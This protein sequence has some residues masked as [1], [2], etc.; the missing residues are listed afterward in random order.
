MR[1]LLLLV[2]AI[3]AFLLAA[4]PAASA[5]EA[6]IRDAEFKLSAGGFQ[7]GLKA[8]AEG[9]KATLSL[10]RHGQVAIYQVPAE[11]TENTVKAKFGKFGE[12]DY[13]FTPA[14]GKNPECKGAD[15][16][17]EG[18]FTGNFDFTGENHY[19]SFEADH[20]HGTFEIFPTE[21][22]EEPSK[23]FKP[24]IGTPGATKPGSNG[25]KDAKPDAGNSEDQ[26]TLGVASRGKRFVSYLLVSPLVTK[27][28]GTRIFFY[29]FRAEKLKGMLVERG[30][31]VAAG[32]GA[33]RWD[34]DAGTAHVEPPAPFTG[35]ADFE[36][37]P[38]GNPIWRGSLGVPV[39]GGKRMRLTGPGFRASLGSGTLLSS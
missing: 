19:V 24:P 34:L 4:S 3:L 15:G 21:G 26:A 29:A 32:L 36:R 8:E 37:R 27:D 25:S 12:L 22:C 14:V 16:T 6:P 39:L 10:F 13:T 33:F 7:I 23:S 17:T 11:V 38:H 18:T 28:G 35:S 20:A 31:E 5:A 30:A 9:E 2:P 1:R